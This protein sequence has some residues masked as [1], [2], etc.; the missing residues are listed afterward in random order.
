MSGDVFGNGMLLSRHTKLIAA[1]NH[2]HIFVDPEPDPE[3]SWIERKRLFDLPRSGWNDYDASAL[4]A[5]GGIYERRA[6]SIALSPQACER[7]G[8]PAE[9]MAPAQLIQALLRQKVDLLW[10]GGIG[11]YVKAPSESHA[12]AGDRANDALR[13][14]A[15]EIR[16]KVVGEGANLAVT[17]RARIALAL[18]GGRI[19]T[20]AIDNSAGVDTSDHEVNIKIAVSDALA[21][22]LLEPAQRRGFLA[23]MTDDVER[24]VLRDNYL[25]TLAL[26]LTEAR[27]PALL[28][29]HARLMRAMERRGRLDRAVEFL[30]DDEALAQ[31]AAA[32]RGLTRPEIAVLLA[33]VKNGLYDELLASPLPDLPELRT[34]LLAYFPRALREL[35]G[36]VLPHHRLRREIV[37]TIV[38]NALVNRMGPSFVE[39][40]QSRTGRDAAAIAA[41]FLIVRELF[42]LEAVWAEVEALDN[43]VPASTQTTLFQTI[44]QIVDQAV[45]WFL[46]SGLALDPA[47]RVAQFRPGIDILAAAMGELLPARELA[48]NAARRTGFVDAG[49]PDAIAGRIVTLNTLST[50]MDIV[51]IAGEAGRDVRDVARIYL[52]AGV[53]FGLLALRRQARAMVAAT[54]WQRLA[55]DALTEDAF[56]Q[57]REIVRLLVGGA[58]DAAAVAGRTGPGTPLRDVVDEI[59]RTA[60]PDLAMLTV[61]ARRIRAAVA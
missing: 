2:Q 6:K 26:S 17:Q 53:E 30:P 32:G 43:K 22:G 45:R 36:T 5:G 1:F 16:A 3:R 37:A 15:T 40:A 41:A 27:A 11:T 29:T 12:Q 8:L 60:P 4:S 25:Q 51:Q 56:A 21:A 38:A 61:A 52:Q 55:A 31:R 34:E 14:D 47:A 23:S 48:N 39:E 44:A 50:A 18:Q 13:S 19:N 20:D 28:D 42:D 10:F 54:P 59:A 57:Q 7:L 46:N 49:A 9:P 24:H 58:L 35:A 33:Y